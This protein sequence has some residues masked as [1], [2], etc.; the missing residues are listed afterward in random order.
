MPSTDRKLEL[1]S[2]TSVAQTAPQ[3]AEYAKGLNYCQD[4]I[5]AS[6]FSEMMFEK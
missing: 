4:V 5:H 1:K 6:V 3:A 2:T